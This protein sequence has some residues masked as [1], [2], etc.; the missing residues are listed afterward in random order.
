VRQ[1]AAKICAK[2]CAGKSKKTLIL[3]LFFHFF[4]AFSLKIYYII[5]RGV[6]E[7]PKTK[8]CN[9]LIKKKGGKNEV[10]TD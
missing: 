10:G 6:N 7:S 2:V 4:V 1:N 8:K 5:Y 3:L 9:N